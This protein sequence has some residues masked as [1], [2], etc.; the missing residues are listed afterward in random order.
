MV[1]Q[2]L[3]LFMNLLNSFFRN[4]LEFWNEN[5]FMKNKILYVYQLNIKTQE[6]KIIEA[7]V[8]FD[9]D[10]ELNNRTFYTLTIKKDNK[11]M[12]Q[13]ILLPNQQP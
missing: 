9:N 7:K 11:T 1:L 8:K 12:N 4:Y 2:L 5:R 13:Y 3:K 10:E 6:L